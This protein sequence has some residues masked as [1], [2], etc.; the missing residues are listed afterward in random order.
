MI[1]VREG[2]RETLL[3]LEQFESLARSGELS[4]LALVASETLTG[5]RFLPAREIP[6]FA[7]LYDPRR[8]H[9]R[10][11]FSP[12][13]LPVLVSCFGALCVLLYF[14]AR[15]QGGGIISREVLIAFGASTRARIID[16]GQAWRLLTANV[17]HKGSVHLA[18]N[19]F[20]LLNVGALLEGVYRRVD[21][22]LLV[23][24]SALSTMTVSS[25]WSPAVT[26]GASGV[27]FAFLGCGVM[28]GARYRE[29]LP[30]RYRWYFGTLLVVF[31]GG[32]F[33]LGLQSPN[34]DNAGH[35]GG[36]IA[37]LVA[38]ARFTPRLL[39]LRE[40][41][42]E[43]RRA[44]VKP[45]VLSTVVIAATL[46]AGPGLRHIGALAT[47][48]LPEWGLLIER[49]AHWVLVDS[50][51]GPV[52]YGNGVDATISVGCSDGKVGE[53]PLEVAR[54]F[55]RHDLH[56][57]AGAGLLATLH[58]SAPVHAFLGEGNAV[59][60]AARI[61]FSYVATDGPYAASAIVFSRGDLSSALVSATR[62]EAT[63]STHRI[64]A[65]LRQQLRFVETRQEK[66]ARREVS[67]RP[68]SLRAWLGLALAHQR[69]GDHKAA[70]LAFAKALALS[71]PEPAAEHQ[72]RLASA[73]F[74]LE[75]AQEPAR[76][77]AE[78]DEAANLEAL[79]PG[80]QGLL[81][82][83]LLRSGRIERALVEF[84][85]YRATLRTEGHWQELR[86]LLQQNAEG[87]P[88]A[89]VAP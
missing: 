2:E 42:R 7:G 60:Q 70:R 41:P 11:H 74:E 81:V 45:L 69:G 75:H 24:V 56:D 78:L 22:L 18:L 65:G 23:V 38:G 62:P 16:D 85:R 73:R 83:A 82:E 46:A 34:T 89:E 88:E 35:V 50:P 84:D 86:S 77:V 33:Y 44:L 26:V 12:G 49:P 63:P 28:F 20:A 9:F 67:G 79:D 32:M 87:T 57:L 51:F 59:P 52:T 6:L 37:G 13:R 40:S 55:V 58:T 76:A 43:P 17:L 47:H 27:V 61:D 64:L 30:P 8:L 1:R 66:L 36:F 53:P 72:V 4:P 54:R 48:P 39:R 29:V 3:S 14:L 15:W 31:V 10:R 80:A 71:R 25:V 19:L 68:T 5:G 21:L